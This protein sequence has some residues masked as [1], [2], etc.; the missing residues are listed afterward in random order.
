M[1][2]LYLNAPGKKD[3]T[4][5]ETIIK[6]K[7][8]PGYGLTEEMAKLPPGTPV[9]VIRKDT[10][11]KLRAVGKLSKVKETWTKASWRDRYDVYIDDLKEKPFEMP[12]ANF[13]HWGVLLKLS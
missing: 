8:G 10:R 4:K 6:S 1:V 13:D 9:E 5:F 7:I 12:P 11:K 3:K 2:V